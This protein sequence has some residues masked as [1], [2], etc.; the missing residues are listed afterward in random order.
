MNQVWYVD[1]SHT[2]DGIA[3]N[4]GTSPDPFPTIAALV[5]AGVVVDA[6]DTIFLHEGSSGTTAYVGPVTI[7]DDGQRLFGEGVALTIPDTLTQQ[8]VPVPGP[9]TLLAA[10][11]H[12][13]IDSA[14]ND[15]DVTPAGGTFGGIE[16]MG[17]HGIGSIHGINV[18]ATGTDNVEVLI[19]D[20][21]IGTATAGPTMNGLNAVSTSVGTLE[22]AFND[23]LINT[24]AMAGAMIDGSGGAG[25][26]FIS[27]F[28]GNTVAGLA[29][30][31][32]V[33]G[34]GV[35]VNTVT[36]DAD[37]STVND[38]DAVPAGAT[39]IGSSGTSVGMA[40]MV[41]TT[42]SGNVDFGSPS[43]VLDIFAT[44][45]GLTATGT[46]VFTMGTPDTGFQITVPAGSTIASGGATVM[47]TE[48]PAA[49]AKGTF[50]S[51]TPAV[52]LDPLTA[53]FAMGATGGAGVTVVG[54]GLG[55]TDVAGTLIFSKDS[56]LDNPAGLAN[57]T[58][59]VLGGS[60]DVT[61]SGDLEDSM[62]ALIHIEGTT[63]GT[64]TFNDAGGS[65]HVYSATGFAGIFLDDVQ[66]NVTLDA[67]RTDIT[68]VTS[69]G[70][71][72][73]G[74]TDGTIRFDDV[75][76]DDA[77]AEA[78]EI[79]ASGDQIG[80]TIDFNNVDVTQTGA[81]QAV[82]IRNLDA[83]GSVDFDSSSLIEAT[84]AASGVLIDSNA[85]GATIDF[86]GPVDMG[87][88]TGGSPST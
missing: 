73:F 54:G 36:F 69:K 20:N 9:Q 56:D 88:G 15:V 67:F 61:Y 66:G 37:P 23:N 59:L 65:N 11:T 51:A 53:F 86:N 80:G 64:I 81:G 19:T 38:F 33:A 30:P 63:G 4:D 71:Q 77:G 52:A 13:Q 78:I 50:V 83:A 27:S 35:V 8:T 25:T 3:T 49:I 42:V 39:A 5:A 16:V 85:A 68:S 58:F 17:I 75:D 43:G 82:L 55:L 32:G 10:G 29:A 28:E 60:A 79:S 47:L 84:G 72:I 7:D 22:V 41:L 12:P 44:T 87:T 24:V 45:A 26:T 1:N 46:G 21:I 18:V 14:T 62:R 6:N 76:I 74:N 48:A 40:G 31:A 34:T 2:P 57:A 70:V